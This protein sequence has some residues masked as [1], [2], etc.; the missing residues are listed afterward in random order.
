MRHDFA[1]ERDKPLFKVL[2]NEMLLDLARERPMT[3]AKLHKSRVISGKLADRYGEE[4]VEVIADA[5]EDG[6]MRGE[7][8]TERSAE[9]ELSSSQRR[10]FDNLRQWRKE[11]AM[12]RKTDA[13]LILAKDVMLKLSMMRDLPRSPGELASSGLFETWRTS[14]Y[15]EEILQVIMGQRSTRRSKRRKA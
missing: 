2:G 1:R 3:I 9:D 4:I 11:T 10:V 14:C 15:G 7:L 6:P 5:V 13:S 12:Q 8:V